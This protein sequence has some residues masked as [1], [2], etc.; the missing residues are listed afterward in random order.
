MTGYFEMRSG[1]SSSD[2]TAIKPIQFGA[3]DQAPLLF[4]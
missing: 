4:T 2:E 3:R 1:L